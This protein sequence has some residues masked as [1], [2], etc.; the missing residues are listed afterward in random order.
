MR[1]HQ[2][3]V[4]GESN[5]ASVIYSIGGV[6][7]NVA[8][9]LAE[10]VPTVLL[11]AT[12]SDDE[13]RLLQGQLRLLAAASD[14]G[15]HCE[16]QQFDNCAADLYVAIQMPDGQLAMGASSTTAIEQL[17]AEWALTAMQQRSV[18]ASWLVLDSNLSAET[19][20]ALA[21]SHAGSC[22]G[23]GVSAAKIRRL[24]PSLADLDVIFM[25]RQEAAVLAD[26]PPDT[27]PSDLIVALANSGLRAAVITDKQHP[28]T[29]F[30]D[31]RSLS[32][33]LPSPGPDELPITGTGTDNGAGDALA[34]ATITGISRGES[35][36]DSVAQHGMP[37]ARQVLCGKSSPPGR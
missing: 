36:G 9:R 32:L 26:V 16:F 3:A 24:A 22:I 21:R 13:S 34:A 25:N 35:L 20:Q 5:P 14:N 12:G 2:P 17:T 15:F 37:A 31:G 33:K 7:T 30:D 8:R 29:V 23:L 10:E 18:T 1:S 4:N 11:S 19:I 28:V 6:A 27:A